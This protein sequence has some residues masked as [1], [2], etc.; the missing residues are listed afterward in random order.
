MIGKRILVL[1]PHPDD[2]AAGCAAAITR[3]RGQGAEILGAYL[4]SGV[5]APE[6]LWP[7]QRKH[8]PRRI[9]RRR[10]EAQ[11]AAEMLGLEMASYQTIPTRTLRTALEGTHDLLTRLIRHHEPDVLWTPAYEGGHQDHD[12]ASFLASTFR[13]VL[14]VWEFSEYNF[15]GGKVRSQEFFSPN[16][17][18]KQ[19]VLTTNEQR[20]KRAVLR[21]YRSERNN[22]SHILTQ[23]EVFRPLAEYDYRRPPYPGKLF[24]QR[25]DWV[26]F[27]PRIDKTKPE[28]VCTAIGGFRFPPE[29][30]PAS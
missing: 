6:L 19:I 14:T 1:I 26:P 23:R 12:A 2:E 9:V 8:Q 18:E 21:T 29:N 10:R 20:F 24:Y 3:A 30:N 5:P 28:E 25:F 15:A 27:H 4:T 13:H 11:W 7:W 22:L 17:T 16:G